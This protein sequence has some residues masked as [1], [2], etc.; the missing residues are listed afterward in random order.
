METAD[1]QGE[2]GCA[3]LA[4]AVHQ[5]GEQR[6]ALQISE[7]EHSD[8]E[9]HT[10][11]CGLSDGTKRSGWLDLHEGVDEL[12]AALAERQESERDDAVLCWG[13]HEHVASDDAKADYR[14]RQ[15]CAAVRT[16]TRTC[17]VCRRPFQIVLGLRRGRPC[18]HCS[19]KC[20]SVATSRRWRARDGNSGS[21]PIED[22]AS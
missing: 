18:T 21:L 3:H 14:A 12:F 16:E 4:N 13:E 11:V 2:T 22:I 20:T 1:K 6:A 15:R 9:T 10:M 8:R 19:P 5:R 7:R 17:P